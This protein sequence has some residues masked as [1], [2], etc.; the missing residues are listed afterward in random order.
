MNKTIKES[1]I[2]K[3]LTEVRITAILPFTELPCDEKKG[4]KKNCLDA[5][6]LFSIFTADIIKGNIQFT[7]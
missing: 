2:V 7:R 3:L 5:S 6:E 4:E 1:K